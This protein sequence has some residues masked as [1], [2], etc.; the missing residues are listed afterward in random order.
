MSHYQATGDIG[1]FGLSTSQKINSLSWLGF[2]WGADGAGTAATVTYSFPPMGAHWDLDVYNR[3]YADN[4][5]NG[6]QP[7]DANQKTAAVAAL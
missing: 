5:P 6:F 3:P 1:T 2:K 7:F 4:E